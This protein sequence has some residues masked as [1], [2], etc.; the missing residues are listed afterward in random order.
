LLSS[1]AANPA[2]CLAK[3]TDDRLGLTAKI[4]A[5]TSA[6]TRD[7]VSVLNLAPP[8]LDSLRTVQA[9]RMVDV[10][11]LTAFCGESFL[12]RGPARVCQPRAHYRPK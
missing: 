8:E 6:V 5:A 9:D 2:P 10:G 7:I 4:A 1:L 3:S 12:K 11:N